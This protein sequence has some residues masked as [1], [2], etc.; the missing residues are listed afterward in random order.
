MLSI[1]SGEIIELAEDDHGYKNGGKWSPDGRWISYC[2]DG[3]VKTR[4]GG[5]IWAADFQELLSS[6]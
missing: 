2:S 4:P 1:D 5:E 6:E 3:E